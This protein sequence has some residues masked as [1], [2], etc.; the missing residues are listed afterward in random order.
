MKDLNKY[1]NAFMAFLDKI[2]EKISNISF[3]NIDPGKNSGIF[4][5]TKILIFYLFY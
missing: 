1:I 3:L 5:V 4:K 2:A